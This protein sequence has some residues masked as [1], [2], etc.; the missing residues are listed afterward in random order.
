MPVSRRT[1]LVG[2]AA[3]LIV[4]IAGVF[5]YGAK[6]RQDLESSAITSATQATADLR[7]AAGL[8]VGAPRAADALRARDVDLERRLAALRAEDSARN[9]RLAEAAELYLV[10][11]QAIL[12]NHAEASRAFTAWRLSRAALLAHLRNAGERGPGWIQ[13][14]LE[15]KNRAERDNFD[16]RTA[17]EALERLLKAHPDTQ[18]KLH[19]VAPSVPL[20]GDA[21]RRA[22]QKAA[23]DA[24]DKAENDLQNLRRLP[25]S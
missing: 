20:L 1:L 16:A 17:A 3:V 2:A 15:L 12:R 13:Q 11:A 8:A 6:K 24:V 4:A 7:E 10:D 25:V 9:P 14:A 18:A 19:A 22:L 21:E 23:H 5:L